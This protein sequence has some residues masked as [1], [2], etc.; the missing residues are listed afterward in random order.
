MTAVSRPPCRAHSGEH[1]RTFQEISTLG[2]ELKRADPVTGST[3]TADVAIVWDWENWWAVEGCYHPDHTYS[4]RDAVTHHYRA[5]WPQNIATD[6]VTLDD[7]LSRYRTIV[8][9]NQYL[10]SH[11][12]RDH[13]RDYVVNGGHALISYFSGIVDENDRVHPNAYPGGL[14]ELIGAWIRE[15]SPLA[16]DRT[17]QV[18]GSTNGSLAGLTGTITRWQDD[19][20]PENAKTWATYSGGWLSGRPAVTDNA[21]GAGHV[22]Y[23]GTKLD[24]SSLSRVLESVLGRA[25][26]RPV[27][28]TPDG[29]EATERHNTNGSHL[30][31]LNHNN[32]SASVILQQSGTDLLSGQHH[33]AG[34][35]LTLPALGVAVITSA[36]DDA[37]RLTSPPD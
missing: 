3:T 20:V 13:L 21:L 9:P 19:L 25:G 37:V 15:F 1:S 2:D 30:F 31:L 33:D 23:I 10:I 17:E 4:Y 12:Q 32:E 34:K 24:D 27:L 14:R 22:T 35:T 11:A 36:Q 28:P 16:T 26:V 8:I 6:V 18:T 7:D 5:L 29:V